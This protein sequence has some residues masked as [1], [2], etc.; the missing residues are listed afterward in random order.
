MSWAL[1]PD[2]LEPRVLLSHLHRVRQEMANQ[3][4][5]P[6]LIPEEDFE[7]IE[8]VLVG[9]SATSRA[10]YAG[11]HSDR[12]PTSTFLAGHPGTSIFQGVLAHCVEPLLPTDDLGRPNPLAH[13]ADEVK[14]ICRR[15]G[16][17]DPRWIEVRLHELL[18]RDVHPF[19]KP[20]DRPTRIGDLAEVILVGDWATALPQA[21]RVSNAIRA[22]LQESPALERHVIH[23][24]DTYYCGLREEYEHRFLPDW[25]V[26]PGSEVSSWSL[27]GNHDMYAGGHGYFQTLLADA[28]FRRQQGSS[29]FILRNRHW[30]VVGLDSAYQS[31]DD[32][33]LSAGQKDW[34]RQAINGDRAINGEGQGEDEPPQTILLSHHQGF[35]AFGDSPVSGKL[36]ADVTDGLNGSRVAGWIWGHEH[37]A[38]VYATDISVPHYD[39]VAGYTATIGNGGV[40]QLLTIGGLPE[41]TVDEH[42]VAPSRGGW[43]FDGRYTVEED[44]WAL[45]GYAVLSFHERLLEVTYFDE[46]GTRRHGPTV[47]EPV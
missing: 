41:T 38:T 31:P 16:P 11:S 40:P 33:S 36:A 6:P 15:F 4:Y 39:R 35:T 45:G 25:P 21:I 47:I 5:G 10:L 14:D 19:V 26:D 2:V 22:R 24:G 9:S 20:P 46:N 37:R 23:L 27:N 34:L 8:R 44:T 32:P 30:Q 42:L 43:Q 28:R 1:H 18:T 7:E 12:P 3:T 29:N 17:C 13:W